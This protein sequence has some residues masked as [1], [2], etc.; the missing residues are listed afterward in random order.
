MKII[1]L[2]INAKEEINSFT[3]LFVDGIISDLPDMFCYDKRII[4]EYF[5]L[6]ISKVVR[7]QG[8]QK[9][10]VVYFV[11]NSHPLKLI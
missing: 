6:Y 5:I 8:R 11:A 9:A 10:Y 4:G 3:A 1:P 7:I 2:T